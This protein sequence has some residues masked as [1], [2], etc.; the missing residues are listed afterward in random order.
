[1]SNQQD[2][3]SAEPS[4]NEDEDICS[5]SFIDQRKVND[6][7]NGPRSS[8]M[9]CERW[10]SCCYKK[11][12]TGCHQEKRTKKS[13][14]SGSTEENKILVLGPNGAGKTTM[15]NTIRSVHE[16]SNSDSTQE[17]KINAMVRKTD[18]VYHMVQIIELSTA[19]EFALERN[20][21]I[22][23]AKGIIFIIP[24]DDIQS[25]HQAIEIWDEIY[26][27]REDQF[28]IVLVGNKADLI[29]QREVSRE[30]IDDI[31][32]GR[33]ARY[34]EGSAALNE[35]VKEVFTTL[36]QLSHDLRLNNPFEN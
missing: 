36:L 32:R 5:G 15:I 11:T 4:S 19:D 6:A 2:M 29:E 8:R 1:M 17:V 24:L 28:P 3:S 35:S 31:L 18:K 9:W 25:F 7:E 10:F 34:V 33:P 16:S 23:N 14:S 22:R 20:I 12:E 13:F 26:R 30:N 27:L 21:A